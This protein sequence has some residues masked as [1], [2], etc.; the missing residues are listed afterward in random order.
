MERLSLGESLGGAGLIGVDG[1]ELLFGSEGK[2]VCLSGR[3]SVEAP[4]GIA[5]RLDKLFFE[6]ALGLELVDKP[7]EVALVGGLVFGRQDDNVASEAMAQGVQ[8]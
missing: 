3:N 4:G 7:L 8:R 6:R 2:V 5:E 1:I